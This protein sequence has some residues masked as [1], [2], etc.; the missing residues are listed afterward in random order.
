MK[1]IYEMRYKKP[2]RKIASVVSL[3]GIPA[4]HAFGEAEM[5]L[6]YGKKIYRAFRILVLMEEEDPE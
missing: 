1:V 6:E 4:E 5:T 2:G 3:N